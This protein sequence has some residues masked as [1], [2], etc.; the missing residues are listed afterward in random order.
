MTAEYEVSTVGTSWSPAIWVGEGATS[1]LAGVST[2]VINEGVKKIA[3]GAFTTWAAATSLKSVVLPSTLTNIGAGAFAGCE[4]LTTIYC[5]AESAP[6]LDNPGWTDHFKGYTSWDCIFLNC[7]LYV[8]SEAA[9]ETYN[10]QGDNWTYWGEFYNNDRIKVIPSTPTAVNAVK[11]VKTKSNTV[12]N[13]AGQRVNGTMK[14]LVVKDGKKL[15][16]K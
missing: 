1:N 12:Y 16:T 8:P 14:G 5:Y 7:T 11:V 9:K 6:V 13:L 10:Q 3:Q 15:M 2:V 4:G